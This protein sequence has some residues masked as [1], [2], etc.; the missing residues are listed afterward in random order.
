MTGGFS[1]GF[2]SKKLVS[3]VAHMGWAINPS[4]FTKKMISDESIW[5]SWPRG[6][7]NKNVMLQQ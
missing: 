2:C 1:E 4:K 3:Y 7:D 5:T 6:G